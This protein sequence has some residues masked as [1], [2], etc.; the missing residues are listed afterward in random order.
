MYFNPVRKREVTLEG[1]LAR[2]LRTEFEPHKPMGNIASHEVSDVIKIWLVGLHKEIAP[3]IPRAREW[4]DK[5]IDQDEDFGVD[6][7][8]H[9]VTLYWARAL[10]EWLENGWDS[11][12]HW[13][14]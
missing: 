4:L 10:C 6:I 3:V 8:F 13:E 11:P 7:N 5:A 14:N 1:G 12:G 9:R 2:V